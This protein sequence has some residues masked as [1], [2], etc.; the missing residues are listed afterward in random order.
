MPTVSI[1]SALA[2]P[3]ENRLLYP[4]R[5]L[6]HH[7]VQA[8]GKVSSRVLSAVQAV[9]EDYLAGKP[10]EG[11]VFVDCSTVYPT[12]TKE[13]A[14][15]YG[16]LFCIPREEKW[17]CNEK[18]RGMVMLVDCST[19]Y[20][21]T[22]KELADRYGWICCIPRP[23]KLRMMWGCSEAC[24]ETDMLHGLR[25][26][27]ELAH[28]FHKHKISYLCHPLHEPLCLGTHAVS[29]FQCRLHVT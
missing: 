21:A 23:E 25:Q 26:I 24:R 5:G 28:L 16:W 29:V 18:C 14:A 20:P 4:H 13:L 11:S 19:V 8:Q 10:K 17:G 3:T 1:R 6:A 9:F 2:G 22:T 15:R 7:P 27:N 12:T